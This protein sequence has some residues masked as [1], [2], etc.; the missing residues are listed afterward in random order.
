LYA[1][2]FYSK[3]WAFWSTRNAIST[4]S[5]QTDATKFALVERKEIEGY[6]HQRT[7]KQTDSVF[8]QTLSLWL[9]CNGLYN[10]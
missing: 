5:T 8:L 10:I 2:H 7:M 4:V 9:H 1:Q 6:T 3:Y